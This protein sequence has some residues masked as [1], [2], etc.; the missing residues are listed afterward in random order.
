[1]LSDLAPVVRHHHERYDG[2]GYG[3]GLAR[4]AIP[5]EARILAVADSFDAM[6]SARPYR[7]AM[8]VAEAIDEMVACSGDQFDPVIVGHLIK[9]LRVETGP[10]E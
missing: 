2:G 7:P 9:A 6:T 10:E 4:H 1:M 5:L 3:Y 8:A